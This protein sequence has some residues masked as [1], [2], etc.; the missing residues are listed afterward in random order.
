MRLEQRPLES[1]DIINMETLKRKAKFFWLNKDEIIQIRD[2]IFWYFLN[3]PNAIT[4]DD[5]FINFNCWKSNNCFFSENYKRDRKDELYDKFQEDLARADTVEYFS[6]I[7][8]VLAKYD[9]FELWEEVFN[10]DLVIN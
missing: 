5:T 4:Q 8:D 10:K 1:F 6:S 7:L 2:S 3:Y 9:K